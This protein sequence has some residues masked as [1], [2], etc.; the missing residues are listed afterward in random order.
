MMLNDNLAIFM[1]IL[2]GSIIVIMAG[3]S[4]MIYKESVEHRDTIPT[5]DRYE[6]FSYI[7]LLFMLAILTTFIMVYGPK[8]ALLVAY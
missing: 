1:P 8:S 5:K 7:T 3:M 4:V 6:M 2:I